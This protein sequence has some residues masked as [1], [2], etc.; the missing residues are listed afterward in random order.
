MLISS[1]KKQVSFSVSFFLILS[2]LSSSNLFAAGCCC[3]N[4]YCSTSTQLT[5]SFC[6]TPTTGPVTCSNCNNLIAQADARQ[7][8]LCSGTAYVRLTKCTC[9][10]SPA[11][12]GSPAPADST[13]SDDHSSDGGA[14]I[15]I[16]VGSVV[17][18][19]A[20]IAIGVTCCNGCGH[21]RNAPNA[22]PV[23]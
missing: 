18:L 12:A 7:K 16:A 14:A 23:P 11:S 22:A 13:A 5:K 20:L 21:C 1:L 8:S 19:I 2:M 17:G 15:G 10:S 4:M 9:S 3:Y 6:D